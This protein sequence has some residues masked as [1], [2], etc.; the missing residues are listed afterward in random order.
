MVWNNR[1]SARG[2][3]MTLLTALWGTLV[4]FSGSFAAQTPPGT[5][6]PNVATHSSTSS[7]NVDSNTV[8][9]TIT[10]LNQVTIDPPRTSFIKPGKTVTVRH[11]ITNCGNGLD[12]FNLEAASPP[13]FGAQ[14]FAADGVT[15]LTDTTGDGMV[16]T[17]PLA[18]GAA[19]EIVIVLSSP[20]AALPGT[21]EKTV[22]KASSA[23]VPAT[24]AQLI[25]TST[26][27]EP[28]FW[29]PLVKTVSPAGQ[30]AP[31]RILTYTNTFGNSGTDAATNIV[32]TDQLDANLMYIDESA[33]PPPGLSGTKIIYDAAARTISWSIPAIPAGYA[34]SVSFK[35]RIN[36]DTPSDT[37]IPNTIRMISD[38]NTEAQTSNVVSTAVVEQP[39]RIS[40][41]AHKPEAE[42]GDYV[43]YTV[44]VENVSKTLTV[45][46]ARVIDSLPQ[47]FR[48]MKGSSVIDSLTSLEPIGSSTL[49]WEL[50]SL[51]PG[52]KR[53][54]LFRTL[55]SIDAPSGNGVCSAMADG[56]SPNGY[57]L[58]SLPVMVTTKVLE[59]VLN[60]KATI[61][62]RVFVDNNQDRMP[63]ENE[64]GI[65]G[66]RI[67]LE[68]GSFAVTD[69][70]GKFNFSGVD[71]GEHVLKM[72]KSS[73]PAG[74]VPIA[75]D[76]TFAG[77][78]NSRFVSVPFGG[79]ARG[80]FAFTPPRTA[81]LLQPAPQN[82]IAPE[83]KVFT[84]GAELNPAPPS[85]EQQ[86]T[87]MAESAQI[88]EPQHGALL[89]K[90]WGDIVIRV[91]QGAEYVLR[92]NGE[93]LLQKQIGK[94]I[95]EKTRKIRIF[96]F[97]GVTMVAGPNKIVLETL[98]P[99][100]Q[101]ERQEIQVVAP[102]DAV[103]VVL[104][105]DTATIPADG[106]TVIPVIV[107]FLD[108][109]NTPAANDIVYTVTADKGEL[110]ETDLDPA[111]PGHQ[112]KSVDGIGR[113]K[114]RS[115]L[116]TGA[117]RIKVSAGTALEGGVDVFFTPELRDWI[118]VGI[119]SLTVGS[120]SI[121]GNVEKITTD[122]RFQEGIYEEGRLAFFAKGK[123]LG[124]YLMT[125][126]YDS[127]KE[128]RTELFQRVEPNRYYPVYGDASEKGTEAESQKNYYVKIEK[129]R[130]SLLVGDFTTNL[131]STEFSRYD[132]SFNGAK[133][134]IDTRNATLRAFG[135]ATN[136]SL[137]KD[138]LPG[139]GTSGYYFLS[140]K[141]IIENTDKIRIEVR[142]RY[143][144][145]RI[146]SSTEKTPYADYSLDFHTGA[147]L[148]R[149]PVA[150]F[151][152]NLNPIRI[153]AVYES[154]D[155]GDDNYIYG[156]RAALRSGHGSELG[157]TAVAEEKGSGTNTLYGVDGV[158]AVNTKT[159][160]KMEVAQ[161]DTL[162]KGT[163]TAWKT[164][165]TTQLEKAKID[166]YYR[167][168]DTN[169]QN[170]SMSGGEAGTEKYGVKI[171]YSLLEK[172]T[173]IADGFVQSDLILGTKLTSS[174]LGV[175]QKFKN[176]TLDYGYKYLQGPDSSSRF[177]A[178]PE[179]SSHMAFAGISGKLTERVDGS[180][181]QEQALSSAPVKDHPSRTLVKLNMKVT[182]KTSAFIT[183]EIQES[184]DYRKNATLIGLTS[185]LR[186]NIILTTNY[187][188]ASGFEHNR[189]AGT[190]V[191]S[192]WEPAK[193]LS[194]TSRTGYQIQNNMTGDRGQALLGADTSWQAT[195]NLRIG[196]KAERVQLVSGT[197]DPNGINTALAL[198]AEFL[199]R[200]DVKTTSRYELRL[201]PNETTN[202][203]ALGTA[204]KLSRSFSLLGKSTLWTS[205]KPT[206]TDILLD[207][208]VGGAYRAPGRNSLYLLGVVRFK[209]DR[210]GS[211]PGGDEIQSLISSIEFSERPWQNLTFHG[212]YAGKYSWERMSGQRFTSYTDMVLAG[213]VYDLDD[214]WD[215]GISAKLMNQ[216]DIHV[217]SLGFIPQVGYRVHKNVR[218]VGGYNYSGLND[219]DLAGE[220]YSTNG[221]FVQLK[222]KF[223]EMTIEEL[224]RKIAS[225][226]VVEE[227]PPVKPL[228]LLPPSLPLPSKPRGMF[229][230][231]ALLGEPVEL[232]GSAEAM[233]LL[234]NDREALFPK[235]DITVTGEAV[236][237]VIDV[238]GSEGGTLLEFRI[239][240]ATP[241]KITSWT[242]AVSTLQ[243]DV[244][245]VI[246]GKG[247]P[248][249]SVTWDGRTDRNEPLKGGEIYQYRLEVEYADGS[250]VSSPF[251]LFGLNRITAVSMSLTGGAFK[252]GS[253]TLSQKA[254]RILQQTAAV[255]RSYPS[256]K[257][258]IEGHT[259]SV[260]TNAA[261][262]E[263]SRKRGQAAA[264]FLIKVEKIPTERIVVRW[265]GKTRPVTSNA[266]PEGR[267]LNRRVEVKGEFSTSKR[268]EIMDRHRTAPFVRINRVAA[269]VDALGRFSRT[270]T[271]KVERIEIEMGDS[272][273]RLVQKSLPLPHVVL[274]EPASGGARVAYSGTAS[275][276]VEVK[277]S[278]RFAG[279]AEPGGSL[280]LDG[281]DVPLATDGTF[282]FSLDLGEGT[283]THWLHV[284]NPE[285]FGMY[286]RLNISVTPEHE[287]VP[288]NGTEVASP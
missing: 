12:T 280:A 184:G 164:E 65:K 169:F 97:I 161:S 44:T 181:L 238:K 152:S 48:Y 182:E 190:E 102:G 132:R 70:E 239:D 162:E 61:L 173:L 260:G 21:V 75:L 211:S 165:L 267:E 69:G 188:E 258:I 251:R 244:L 191:S 28:K 117:E 115:T 57:R 185:K 18:G 248:G 81:E 77:D 20:A 266:L 247:A 223:D 66:I 174:A 140:K 233:K 68:N 222:F 269:P 255:L 114:L 106:T 82:A 206:G 85:L 43:V 74:H 144:T 283:V 47:G 168:V 112:L 45:N 220:G 131:S 194:F 35:A 8:I 105:P 64:T 198:S 142:D 84:F 23:A 54:L 109:F 186:D 156:G 104:T 172:A 87:T 281:T 138:Q 226:P 192:R 189:Q 273:G 199:A 42:I 202:L 98:L 176:V 58:F 279:K 145:E 193:D 143:H 250:R 262:M 261:N 52:K 137:H 90:G 227:V 96:Q 265:F 217:S 263:L 210:R 46:Q 26:V 139:N 264:D 228:Q 60:S 246:S 50:G 15:P 166:G 123:I 187:Q 11:T 72:D 240:A 67:Y 41:R 148:F 180:I 284:R 167:R 17:G 127:R 230:K 126:A 285:G 130:S 146:L 29:D 121:S 16:D 119:G 154:E 89:R 128:K 157:V 51:E 163:G 213:I 110:L 276:P 286:H 160:V 135:T 249:T 237:E 224:Y 229:L 207:G 218:V 103:K 243:D 111:T 13:G 56:V 40:I 151:D 22:I 33:L 215:V 62:G 80:D 235:G 1:R 141:P 124:Q 88:L 236:D 73:I 4:L 39:L 219:R 205:V 133:A 183:Q 158:L 150:S 136:H 225:R 259:D 177:G 86:I 59:G 277:I 93:P 101:P 53:E 203:Y 113:F 92:V 147:L 257:I 76:N 134:D 171:A 216:Y 25:D 14:F 83:E 278:Y 116:K 91:P 274:L 253:T 36:P 125:A 55:V 272:Q 37:V 155:S 94:T 19:M 108:S 7:S 27:V 30:T 209:D 196:A 10:Q 63:D 242:V 118:V 288:L 175:S 38:Q 221:P 252:T 200:E 178:G 179:V 32:I 34:G 245:R 256:E 197:T 3:F 78:G 268:P 254:Q 95:I 287:A 100:G 122:D 120:N 129:D 234:I 195:K 212:K 159:T 231:A 31:G 232:M 5:V 9:V 204:W 241:E 2:F 49:T 275:A 153:V 24:S 107:S 214:Y 99:G 170:L 270:V 282:S 71:A 6:I 79:M 271:E 201:S 208:E 149:E